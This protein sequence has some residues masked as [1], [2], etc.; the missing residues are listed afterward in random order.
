MQTIWVDVKPTERHFP[1]GTTKTSAKSRTNAI[2]AYRY[3]A[4]SIRL[5]R[6]SIRILPFSGLW[7]VGQWQTAT[8]WQIPIMECPFLSHLPVV[9]C[10][11]F[12]HWAHSIKI[13][14]PDPDAQARCW[15]GLFR[16]PICIY[17]KIS[18]GKQQQF[19]VVECWIAG[20]WDCWTVGVGK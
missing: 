20:L 1:H 4:I 12:K 2:M 11:L 3:L 16:F 7:T 17:L 19:R 14:K 6:I 15:P 8:A 5:V 9:R 18:I 13:I 10:Q